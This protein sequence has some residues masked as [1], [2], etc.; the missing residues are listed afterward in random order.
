MDY[1]TRTLVSSLKRNE[2][3]TEHTATTTVARFSPSGFYC[4][5][6]DVTGNVRIWDATQSENILKLAIR[7]LSSKINDLA[8]DGESKRIIVGGE[9][10]DK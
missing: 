7:P 1:H 8:W 4:A 2:L 3:T 9:G 10:K 6:A 5:S